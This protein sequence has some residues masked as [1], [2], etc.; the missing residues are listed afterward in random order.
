MLKEIFSSKF[1]L[2]SELVD[3]RFFSITL[4][5][6]FGVLIIAGLAIAFFTPN[7]HKK[8]IGKLYPPFILFG[9]LGI[10]YVFAKSEELLFLGTWLFL[11][12][13]I[14]ALIIWLTILLIWIAKTAPKHI[15]DLKTES[16]YKKYLPRTKAKS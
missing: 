15:K 8:I 10:I 1:L 7:E 11:L 14:G 13:V 5:A 12:I 9:V 16:R 4:I 6:I 2:N 3:S